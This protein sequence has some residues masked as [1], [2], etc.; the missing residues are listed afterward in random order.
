[1]LENSLNQAII[2]CFPGILKIR[3]VD[4]PVEAL[5]GHNTTIPCHVY[6]Y[7]ESYLDLSKVYVSWTL[8]ASEERLV[9]SSSDEPHTQKRF[10]A[11]IP[12]SALVEGDASLH[13]PNMQFSDE[14]EYTCSVIVTPDNVMSQ[15]TVQVSA[16]PVCMVSDSILVMKPD[17]EKSVTCYVSG[18]HPEVVRIRWVKY[19]KASTNTSDLD[20]NTCTKT[21]VQNPNG[22]YNVRNVLSVTPK[23]AGEDGDLYSCVISH[24]SLTDGLT[25]NI[26][27]SVQPVA[28]TVC[29]IRVHVI[30]G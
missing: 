6:G 20:I 16:Q 11:Y 3:T 14:G 5:L 15:V 22:T 4:S 26:T 30:Q 13:I 17:T 19:T 12:K 27:L 24:R 1:P 7:R 2:F 21:L 29:H 8:K 10:G 25:C 18:F 9:Y 23:S 28:G